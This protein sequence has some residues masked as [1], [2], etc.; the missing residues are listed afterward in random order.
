MKDDIWYAAVL[1]IEAVTMLVLL[2]VIVAGII[3]ICT[4]WIPGVAA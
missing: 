1:A 2:F 3:A 4:A